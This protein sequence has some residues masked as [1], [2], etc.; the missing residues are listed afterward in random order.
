MKKK[1]Q[2]TKLVVTLLLLVVLVGGY[3]A[4]TI[5]MP[6]EDTEETEEEEKIT[7]NTV[8]EDDIEKI[9]YN[10]KKEKITLVKQDDDTWIAT[11]DEKCLVNEYTVD[12]M[13]STLKEVEAS[14]KIEKKD[15]DKETFGFDEPSQEIV[16]T[17]KDGAET[18]YTLGAVNSV[19]DKY[20]FM[21]SGDENAYLIDTTMY[22][23]FDYDLLGLVEL[24]EYPSMGTQ[25]IADYSL[26][27]DGKTLYFVDSKDAAH[28][29]NESEIPE[30]VWKVGSS[31]D[32][33]KKQDTDAA[34]EMVQA[35]IGLTNSSCVTYNKTDKDMKKYGLDNP[36]LTLK[37]NYTEM[38]SSEEEET[39]EE[40]ED[41]T[42]EETEETSESKIIDKSFTVYFGNTDE[43]SGEYYV[44]CE[45]SKAIYTMNVANV[46]T[47]MD[48][49]EAK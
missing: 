47:L 20:Y 25:D 31:K 13:I 3:V 7:V 48:A 35:I 17:T 36:K 37:V 1:Q 45:G 9:V 38:E 49:F 34:S 29:K 21:M 12:A 26:T 4:M 30:C 22:N 18:T 10:N 19:V 15:I 14:R 6:S 32:N 39:T 41:S 23:S 42:E 27:M 28:K 40:S 46:E 5:F 43:K 2:I 8:E 11:N 16:F 24:E 44:Y 33:L